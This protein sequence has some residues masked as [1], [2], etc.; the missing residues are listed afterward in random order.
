L[1]AVLDVELARLPEK[2][3][4]PLILC[5]LEGRTQDEAADHLGLSKNTLR[6]RLDEARM[7]LASRLTHRGVVWPA[8]FSAVLLSDCIALAVP[9]PGLFGS[10]VVAA[11]SVA[12][13]KTVATA[14]S[15]KVAALTEGVLKTMFLT[16]LKIV[17]LVFLTLALLGT[18]IGMLALPAVAEQE[19][20]KKGAAEPPVQETKAPK[21]DLSRL[22]V[23]IEPKTDLQRLHGTWTLAETHKHGK[24]VAAK[25]MAL[26]PDP[27]KPHK[28]A[29]DGEKI[30]KQP[31]TPRTLDPNVRAGGV[32]LH[33]NDGRS[34]DDGDFQL[35]AT[36]NPKEIT[37]TWL[38]RQWVCIYK[39]EG[40][41]LT[42][43]FNP[44]N[45]IRPDAFRTMADSERVLFIYK[46][47]KANQEPKKDDATTQERN[48]LLG[49]WQLVSV[50][51]GSGYGITSKVE[52]EEGLR[53][54]MAQLADAEGRKMPWASTSSTMWREGG[55]S[56][57]RATRPSLS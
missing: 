11:A 18:G 31:R 40:D 21:P 8:V 10:T 44:K 35:N 38:F 2:W 27:I 36:K 53:A 13:G 23:D 32:D 12:A 41:T 37:M 4:L 43:C 28:L 9:A 57:P 30:P 24:K 17:T 33:S 19:G 22:Q 16:K 1:R 25:D 42:I 6:N 47:A 56:T 34:V 48:K 52:L 51:S 45:Y 7:A 39:V 29:I 14:A 55:S 20:A 54:R 50:K 3:R 49:T 26:W 15:V 5:Y 46:R